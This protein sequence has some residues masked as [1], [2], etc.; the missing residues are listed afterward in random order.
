LQPTSA[1]D[2]VVEARANQIGFSLAL[3]DQNV[4][5]GHTVEGV[6][7]MGA[8][9]RPDQYDVLDSGGFSSSDLVDLAVVINLLG[10]AACGVD[11][12]GPL[13]RCW[14]SV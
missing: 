6:L 11:Q 13:T 4:A 14:G 2:C 5:V 1:H 10:G 9:H 8:A 7:L 3:P 12:L